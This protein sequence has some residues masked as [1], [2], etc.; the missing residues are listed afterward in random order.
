[1]APSP[2]GERITIRQLLNR[3]S[4][5]YNYTDDLLPRLTASASW[6]L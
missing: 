3:T 2:G 1:V 6:P 5:L 4:G